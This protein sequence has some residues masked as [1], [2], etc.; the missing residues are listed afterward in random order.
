MLP[1]G[2]Q[3]PLIRMADDFRYRAFISYSHQDRAWASWLHRTLESYRVP[4]RL[5][6]RE[7]LHGRI[8]KRLFPLFRDRDELPS[9][10]ELGAVIDQALAASQHLIVVC[11]PRSASS[12]WVNEEVRHFKSLGRDNRVLCLI[13]DGEP[14]VADDPARAAQECFTPALR[15]RV[16]PQGALTTEPAEPIAADARSH[17]DGRAGARLKLIAGL[18]GVGLDE[19]VRRERQRQLRQAALTTVATMALVAM[20]ATGYRWLQLRNEST[21]RDQA[22][23]VRKG[24][25]WQRARGESAAGNSARAAVLLHELMR[26]AFDSEALRFLM[27][28]NLSAVESLQRTAA[29]GIAAS[30]LVLDPTGKRLVVSGA[31]G[32]LLMDAASFAEIARL[33]PPPSIT[34]GPYPIRPAFSADGRRLFVAWGPF[35]HLP[36]TTIQVYDARSAQLLETVQNA[37]VVERAPFEP[38]STDGAQLVYVGANSRAR[39]RDVAAGRELELP[40]PGAVMVAGFLPDGSA[41]VTAEAS[42]RIAIWDR[43]SL[44]VRRTL[45]GLSG[46]PSCM[47]V[48]STGRSLAVGAVNGALRAWDLRSGGTIIAGGHPSQIAGLQFSGDGARML[49]LAFDSARVWNIQTGALVSNI[50]R[51]LT[52]EALPLMS[53]DA[54]TLLF[55]DSDGVSAY[56][57]GSRQIRFKLD[58]HPGGATA[59]ALDRTERKLLSVGGDQ[60]LAQWRWPVRPLLIV[61]HAPTIEPLGAD[62]VWDVNFDAAGE[63]F[64]TAGSDGEARIYR[65]KDGE[66]LGTLRGN[67]ESVM[68]AE[69][70]P[71]GS[72]VAT[73]GYDKRLRIYDAGTKT[74]LRTI[75]AAVP[76]MGSTFI[77][78][79]RQVLANAADQRWPLWDLASGDPVQGWQSTADTVKFTDTPP[80][81]LR[82]EAN[83]WVAL[84]AETLTPIWEHAIAPVEGADNRSWAARPAPGAA[85]LLVGSAAGVAEVLDAATGRPRARLRHADRPAFYGGRLAA[86]GRYAAL[87]VS[88]GPPLLWDT[89]SGTTTLLVESRGVRYMNPVI[90]GSQIAI[91]GG[92]AGTVGAWDMASGEY[93]GVIAH[94]GGQVRGLDASGSGDLVSSSGDNTAALWSIGLES[95]SVESI[96]R[97]LRCLA[98]WTLQGDALVSRPPE[99]SACPDRDLLTN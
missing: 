31:H 92:S 23:A 39:V 65:A 5:V 58:A 4:A 68:S 88:K 17:A 67:R 82:A 49:S 75:D 87:V 14:H 12:R 10:A 36:T 98:P 42:G 80:Q 74:L 94:H 91:I 81:L 46:V 2:D 62:A 25:L 45:A 51:A 84:D 37:L 93:L 60:R 21:L 90:A 1:P 63:R 28:Q 30:D 78:G 29:V 3:G 95:R 72:L 52:W 59:V 26:L 24:E 96:G 15:F 55:S 18:L 89:A 32:A 41:L 8:P 16:T 38:L 11:S 76:L 35:P 57:L 27:K 22:L 77:R 34:M 64:V 86:D 13:V 69:F 83:K 19:L 71:D 56:D 7:T 50:E 61:R 33:P 43:P 97:L 73:A 70:S 9:S 40:T 54:S 44:R 85:E 53:A 48:S 47:R 66:L 79:N 20:L 6:G 99:V